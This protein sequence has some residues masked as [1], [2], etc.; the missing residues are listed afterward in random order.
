MTDHTGSFGGDMLAEHDSQSPQV[1]V[2]VGSAELLAVLNM[3][4]AAFSGD[5]F[6]LTILGTLDGMK[7]AGQPRRSRR[8]KMTNPTAEIATAQAARMAA[9]PHSIPL[10]RATLA[11]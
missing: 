6:P 9:D 3:S 10:M 7:L 2:A 8:G 4:A 1:P 5:P 11:L